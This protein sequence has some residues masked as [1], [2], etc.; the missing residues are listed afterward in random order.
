MTNEHGEVFFKDRPQFELQIARLIYSENPDFSRGWSGFIAR[1]TTDA[2]DAEFYLAKG[3]RRLTRINTAPEGT[4]V[5]L[6]D[7]NL[8][9]HPLLYAVEVGGWD[10]SQKQAARLREYLD[11]GGTLVVDD[12]HG[13][14]EWSGFMQSMRRVYPDRAVVEIPDTDEV[15]HV[16]YDLDERLQIP[17]LGAVLRGVTYERD[18][19]TP[20]WRGI[21]DDRHRLVVIINHNMDLG[22]AWEHADTREYPQPLTALAYR[23]GVNFIVYSMTH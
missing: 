16:L 17:G 4:A 13:T 20:H 14:L 1:W 8:F 9:D 3:V 15:F 11:R 19:Y 22:D 6:E 21:Y 5:A 7:E 23:Y 12:F 10:L 2:P 18:G